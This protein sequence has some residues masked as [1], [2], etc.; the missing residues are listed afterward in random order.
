M[1][2]FLRGNTIRPSTFQNPEDIRFPEP[3]D[4]E[5]GLRRAQHLQFVSCHVQ[6]HF[7]ISL[8]N[9]FEVDEIIV[10]E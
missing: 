2:T 3:N 5:Q 9:Y 8:K 6:A 7:L 10:A 4:M 1:E